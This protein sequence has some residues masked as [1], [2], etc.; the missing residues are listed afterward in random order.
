MQTQIELTDMKFYAYHGAFPQE[1]MVG[2]TFVVDL[3]ITAPLQRAVESDELAD[4]INYAT[5]YALIEREMDQPSKLIEHAAGRILASL[6]KNF[7]EIQHIRLK[8]S[9]QNPP[10]GGD[11]RY[12][13]VILEENYRDT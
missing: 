11:I 8:L 2:N 1:T 10:F 6:K 3:T 4:T 5:V 9:K 7:P 12:A 13:S